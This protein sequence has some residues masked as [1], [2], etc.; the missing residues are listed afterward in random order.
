[1]TPYINPGKALRELFPEQTKS[2]PAI[3]IWTIVFLADAA[4]VFAAAGYL[5]FSILGSD[6]TAK[7]RTLILGLYLIIALVLFWAETAVYN[8]LRGLFR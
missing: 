3:I 7:E 4:L 5:G 1:M 6:F 2:I 8:K